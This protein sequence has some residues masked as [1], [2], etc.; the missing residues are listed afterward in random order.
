MSYY[1]Q[2]EDPACHA[3]PVGNVAN[4]DNV[5][6]FIQQAN[7]ICERNT[8][9]DVKGH[10]INDIINEL[11]ELCNEWEI[12]ESYVPRRGGSWVQTQ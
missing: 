3:E 2:I 6:Y 11:R 9:Y 5:D 12:T 7:E 10:G 1:D 8:N 4:D